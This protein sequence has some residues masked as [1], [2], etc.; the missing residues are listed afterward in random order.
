M[1]MTQDTD[2]GLPK[3]YD[4]DEA[5]TRWYQQW[6][7]AGLFKPRSTTAS[8]EHRADLRH[9]MPLPMS[10]VHAGSCINGHYQDILVRYHRMGGNTCTPGTDHAGTN[11][12]SRRT[13]GQK[14]Q[15]R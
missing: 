8:R 4:P 9:Q 3:V 10:P 1:Q 13:R 11:I 12:D 7:N 5:E 15:R 2:I 14:A 6:E